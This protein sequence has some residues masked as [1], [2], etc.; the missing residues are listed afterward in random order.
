MT[1]GEEEK[2]N[3][4]RLETP[5]GYEDVFSHF[6]YAVNFTSESITKTLLPSFQT[7][8]IF[9]FGAKASLLS[10]EGSEIEVGNC[11]VLGPIKQAFDYVLPSGSEIL[12]ANFIGD[13]FYRFFGKASEIMQQSLHPDELLDENCFDY[14]WTQL[15]GMEHVEKKISAILAFCQPYLRERNAVVKQLI[16][17]VDQN[18]NTVKTIAE[19]NHQTERNIQL[20]HKKLLGYSAKE[21]NRYQRFL[22]TV[23]MIQILAENNTKVDWLEVVAL[24]GYYDQSQLIKDFKHYIHLSPTQYLRFQQDICSPKG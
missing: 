16:D 7:I 20:I 24:C 11:L 15:N 19:Q 6:Y 4:F 2:Y 22:K 14:L 23:E 1:I 13:A 9:T 5:S 12:V 10:K 18:L 8:L 21:V 17:F 3:S